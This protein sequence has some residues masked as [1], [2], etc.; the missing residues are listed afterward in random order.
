MPIVKIQS[1]ICSTQMLTN[2]CAEY[3][4]NVAMSSGQMT[5]SIAEI[6]SE[7]AMFVNKTTAEKC[8]VT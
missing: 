3:Q 1:N 5:W 4:Q 6:M 8:S 7:I 2:E